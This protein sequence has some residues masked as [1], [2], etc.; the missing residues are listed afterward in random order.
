MANQDLA[1]QSRH[2]QLE[3]ER[4]LSTPV[5]T[6]YSGGNDMREIRPIVALALRAVAVAMATASIAL[7]ALR[8]ASA[9]LHVVLLAVGLFAL[10]IAS[11]VMESKA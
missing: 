4:S 2:L 10:C 8:I 9:E 1:K 6:N 11:I 3:H 7:V 5:A